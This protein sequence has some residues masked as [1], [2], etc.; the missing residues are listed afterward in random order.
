MAKNKPKKKSSL[1]KFG[2]I[3]FGLL[4]MGTTIGMFVG[5]F[6][7]PKEQAV[8]VPN[9]KVINYRLT[10]AQVKKLLLEYYTVVEYEYPSYCLECT[11]FKSYLEY[12]TM[13]SE[14]QVYLQEI[15]VDSSS[16]VKMKVTSLRGQEI[17]HDP[18]M[19]EAKEAI[20]EMLIRS[21]LM[22]LELNI[23]EDMNT[24]SEVNQTNSSMV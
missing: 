12:L 10:E 20:C 7:A 11:N 2:A 4:M 14:N 6:T 8:D 23:P 15:E 24:S 16:P 1:L 5:L 19:E 17:I 21:S 13:S 3:V 18:N 22:C 9:S